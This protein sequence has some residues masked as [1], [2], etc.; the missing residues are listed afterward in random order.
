MEVHHHPHVEKK[1]FKE[2]FLEFLMIFLAVTMGFFAE[3]IREK[4]SE[5][6][7][8]EELARS[9]YQ[10]AYTD[11][12]NVQKTIALRSTKELSLIFVRKSIEDSNMNNPP[13]RFYS[14]FT[15]GFFMTT[16]VTF[17]PSDGVLNQLRNSGTLRY[18]RNMEVQNKIGELS[19]DIA[20]LRERQQQEYNFASTYLRPFVLKHFDFR[21]LDSVIHE[22]DLSMAEALHQDSAQLS[23]S[24][25]LLNYDE[26]SKKE[27]ENLAYYY[28]I[29]MRS[30]RQSQFAQYIKANHE[31]L[32][33]L[34]NEYS[35]NK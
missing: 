30:S 34:R 24:I 32:E 20:K 33:L 27:A 2:Y 19:V 10:E 23:A 29:M 8:A 3:T 17:E 28:V 18:F 4:I 15:W 22:G 11:S 9:L 21:L 13:K 12:I 35:V 26:L 14:A 31:L 16:A 7:Q 25:K 1:N 6:R 5:N